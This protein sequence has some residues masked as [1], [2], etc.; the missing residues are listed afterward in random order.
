MSEIKATITITDL[1]NEISIRV[2]FE[3]HIEKINGQSPV[4][5]LL[6]L[7]AMEFLTEFGKQI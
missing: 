6:A 7:Q 5:H 2:D 3:P 4:V 1:D